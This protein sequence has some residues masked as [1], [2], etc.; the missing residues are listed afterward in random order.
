MPATV[1]T[2]PITAADR[3]KKPRKE[4]ARCSVFFTLRGVSSN[5]NDTLGI[6]AREAERSKALK[7]CVT[8]NW[9]VWTVCPSRNSYVVGTTFKKYLLTAAPPGENVHTSSSGFCC[10]GKS[11]PNERRLIWWVTLKWPISAGAAPAHWPVLAPGNRIDVG[12]IF[13]VPVTR[14]TSMVP[15]KLQP[16]PSSILLCRSLASRRHCSKLL[17]SGNPQRRSRYTARM[18]SQVL[19]QRDGSAAAP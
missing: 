6:I 12:A 5:V 18:S 11:V 2:P 19:Q 15:N 3:V 9:L 14:A 16:S 7:Y 13:K 1:N 8:E 10:P 17:A 4:P